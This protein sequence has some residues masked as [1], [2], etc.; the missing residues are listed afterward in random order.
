MNALR[1]AQSHGLSLAAGIALLAATAPAFAQTEVL[2]EEDTKTKALTKTSTT[3]PDGWKVSAKLGLSANLMTTNANAAAAGAGQEG[4]SFQ[5]GIVLGADANLK[6]GQHGW[7]NK[8]SVQQGQT[9]TPNIASFVKSVDNLELIST[10]FYRFQ[11]PEWLGPFARARLQTQLFKGYLVRETDVTVVR[12]AEE[13]KRPAQSKIPLT[14]SFEPL[15]LRQSAGMFARPWQRDDVKLDAKVGLGV[16]EIL[17]RDGYVVQ[18][19]EDDVITL[20]QLE[21]SVNAGAELELNLEGVLVKDLLTWK[22][23]ANFF[24]PIIT[25]AEVDGK[26]ANGFD[27]LNT[28]IQAGLSLKV[29]KGLSVDYQLLLRKVPL[30]VDGFQVQHGLVFSAG[31]DIL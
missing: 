10:Y 13:E 7:D 24:L 25:N 1:L 16:Q 22:A 19:V 28:D 23:G 14:S 20:K 8:L 6:M 9:K 5:F 27:Y 4:V 17:V 3:V 18:K 11:N 21:S 30:I 12:G 31:F 2:K 15:V 29:V 26:K